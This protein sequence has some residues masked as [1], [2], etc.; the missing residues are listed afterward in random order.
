MEVAYLTN[1][2]HPNE[3]ENIRYSRVN[4]NETNK[5]LTMLF[6]YNERQGTRQELARVLYELNH[7]TLSQNVRSG[8]FIDF[9]EN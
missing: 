9:D 7:V 6:Q 8:Y 4:E 1:K 2:F 5:A 3:I